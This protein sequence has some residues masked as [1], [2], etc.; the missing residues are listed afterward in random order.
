MWGV[1]EPHEIL[2]KSD[3]PILLGV[4]DDILNADIR[5]DRCGGEA[6]ETEGDGAGWQLLQGFTK[7]VHHLSSQ[8]FTL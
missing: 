7:S 4:M 5:R 6:G 2:Q 8:F 3:L 1:Q